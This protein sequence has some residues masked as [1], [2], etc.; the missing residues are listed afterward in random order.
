VLA[1]TVCR[2]VAV[3]TVCYG[4]ATD[5]VRSKIYS[6]AASRSSR[7]C[8]FLSVSTRLVISSCT[9]VACEEFRL[10]DYDAKGL[11]EAGLCLI[12]IHMVWHTVYT[13]YGT[14]WYAQVAIYGFCQH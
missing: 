6:K 13:V 5:T 7:A 10:Y 3:C 1:K 14:I 12:R 9:M 4:V 2:I 8:A 11:K